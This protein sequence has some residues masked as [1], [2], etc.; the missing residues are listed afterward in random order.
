MSVATSQ[1]DLG[2]MPSIDQVRPIYERLGNMAI[3][4]HD[5]R[6]GDERSGRTSS[7]GGNDTG[8]GPDG[9]GGAAAGARGSDKGQRKGAGEGEGEG[10]GGAV[11]IRRFPEEE[12]E[13]LLRE[14][15]DRFV[16][17]P[18]KY[19]EVSYHVFLQRFASN[20][21]SENVNS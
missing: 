10:D 2:D 17:F 14:S 6:D 19:R 4:D 18:I 11:K 5:D 20:V 15:N 7:R 13:D 8:D 12:D 3:G 1:N 21:Q 16:L 9:R